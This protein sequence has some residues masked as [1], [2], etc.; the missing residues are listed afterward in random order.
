MLKIWVRPAKSGSPTS[1]CSSSRP[2]RSTAGSN[3]SLRFVIPTTKTLSRLCMPSNLVKSWFTTLS[4][5]TLAV[6]PP[7]PRAFMIASISS[8]IITCSLLLSPFPL[9]SFSAGANRSR[10]FSSDCP[11]NRCRISGPFTIFGGCAFNSRP[12]CFAT[13][14]FPVPGGPYSNMP[15]TCLMP[16]FFTTS[17]STIRDANTRLKIVRNSLSKP[18]T[19]YFS[20]DPFE[21]ISCRCFW[22]DPGLGSL[23]DSGIKFRFPAGPVRVAPSVNIATPKV[24]AFT[25]VVFATGFS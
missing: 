17:G 3:K 8:K 20:N 1:T 7:D 14:V 12:S 10:M 25:T 6:A 19:P 21:S 5:T 9:N 4:C 24:G 22:L 18:P 15:F 13:S 16:N 23:G 11:T 2:G